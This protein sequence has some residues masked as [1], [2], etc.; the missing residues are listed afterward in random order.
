MLVKL[1]KLVLNAALTIAIVS[2]MFWCVA[3]FTNWVPRDVVMHLENVL[4]GRERLDGG[5]TPGELLRHAEKRLYGHTRL[6]IVFLPVLK[7]IQRH[8]ERP[9][10]IEVLPPLG[11]GQQLFPIGTTGNVTGVH[12]VATS[13]ELR[14]AFGNAGP[15]W[16]IEILPGVYPV[17]KKLVTAKAGNSDQPI[18]VRTASP[19]KV[20]IEFNTEEG[21]QVTQPYWIF[22]NLNIKGVCP[23]DRYCEHAFHIVGNARHTTLRNNRMED[24]NA[25]V[26]V[27][28]LSG[29]WPDDGLMAFNTLTNNRRRE[30][31]LPVTPFDLVGAS[32][33]I[34]ADNLVSNFIKGDGDKVSYGIFMKGGGR[35]GRIERNLIICTP[36]DISQPGV[37][38]GVSFGGGGTGK[39]YCRDG[40]CKA[41]HYAGT[42]ANNI[43]A[44][45]NDFGIDAFR[46][47]M[48]TIAHNTLINTA[49]IDVRV[50]PASAIVSGNLLEGRIRTRNGGVIKADMN[51]VRSMN[52][53]FRDPDKL[54]LAFISPRENI[55]TAPAVNDDFCRK[56]RSDGSWA[57]AHAGDV[58]CGVL[59]VESLQ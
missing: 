55:P 42:A 4:R 53:V 49:G 46:S 50:E 48:I 43:I 45:C 59:S 33:W 24:F 25:H 16:V 32:R 34:V 54:D 28:G 56:K 9:V 3:Q 21:F 14:Q 23:E 18:V 17:N 47:A 36:R 58:P 15:G 5:R 57:G 2:G 10:P 8:I 12:Y 51:D 1:R 6:E 44:H 7:M 31:H 35:E 26:K 20:T 11:K 38:V 40:Q 29:Q 27:N 39:T 19:G 13:G 41:E 37:R 52:A 30:T 22:E